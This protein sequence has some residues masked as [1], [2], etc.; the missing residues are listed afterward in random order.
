MLQAL[1]ESIRDLIRDI[2]VNQ[3]GGGDAEEQQAPEHPDYDDYEFD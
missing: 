1:Q 2:G 3:P